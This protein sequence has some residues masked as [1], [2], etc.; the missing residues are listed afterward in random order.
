MDDEGLIEEQ[1]EKFCRIDELEEFVHEQEFGKEN[2]VMYRGLSE[3]FGYGG[4]V[5]DVKFV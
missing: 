2:G 3:V 5:S 4:L 1:C